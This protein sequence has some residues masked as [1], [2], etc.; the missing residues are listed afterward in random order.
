MGGGIVAQN[1]G[2]IHA[3]NQILSARGFLRDPAANGGDADEYI[4]LMYTY[5][6]SFLRHNTHLASLIDGATTITITNTS[7]AR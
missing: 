7:L 5:S 4:G 1:G 6:S 3:F 2:L